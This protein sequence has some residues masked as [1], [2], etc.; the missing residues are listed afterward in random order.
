MLTLDQGA[1]ELGP[2]ELAGGCQRGRDPGQGEQAGCLRSGEAGMWVRAGPVANVIPGKSQGCWH[3]CTT[4]SSFPRRRDR[5]VD[6]D[7][8]AQPAPQS[9][10]ESGTRTWMRSVGCDRTVLRAPR[11]P[12][13]SP[14]V[15]RGSDSASTE[16]ASPYRTWRKSPLAVCVPN[17][18]LCAKQPAWSCFQHQGTEMFKNCKVHCI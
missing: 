12:R 4:A 1:P 8:F 10:E 17:D 16:P 11:A 9:A 3:H 18:P 7:G 14:A 13:G 5:D 6:I 2:Q 15:P